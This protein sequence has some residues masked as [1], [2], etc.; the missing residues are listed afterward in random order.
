VAAPS[1]R[2]AAE[3]TAGTASC[4]SSHTWTGRALA[5]AAVGAVT[6]E[7]ELMRQDQDQQVPLTPLQLKKQLD[8]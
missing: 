3:D 7:V 2:A 5:A 8:R 1:K 6:H 4:L